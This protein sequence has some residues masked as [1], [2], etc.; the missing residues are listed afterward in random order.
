MVPGAGWLVWRGFNRGQGSK[1]PSR[2]MRTIQHAQEM[3]KFSESL[4]A[5]IDLLDEIEPLFLGLGSGLVTAFDCNPGLRHC[6]ESIGWTRDTARGYLQCADARR[7]MQRALGARVAAEAGPVTRGM[8]RTSSTGVAAAAAQKVSHPA[9][10]GAKSPGRSRA[11]AASGGDADAASP[12]NAVDEVGAPRR[13]RAVANKRVTFQLSEYF[14]R[15]KPPVCSS[16]GA[17][18]ST[19][20]A[21]GA[22]SSRQRRPMR[23]LQTTR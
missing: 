15:S 19:Q 11:T 22:G 12:A 18:R 17:R 10:G 14:M 13:A 5:N 23:R 21:P 9:F 2:P 8:A 4:G 20:S 7:A 3:Q 16:F 1:Q 6:L